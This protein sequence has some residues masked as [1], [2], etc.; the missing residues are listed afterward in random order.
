M[1]SSYYPNINA[2]KTD[3]VYTQTTSKC[4]I[5]LELDTYLGKALIE[6]NGYSLIKINDAA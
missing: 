4:R 3:Y 2:I 1:S 5:Q 6:D